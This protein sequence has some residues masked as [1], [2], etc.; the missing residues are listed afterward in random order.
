MSKG[1][2]ISWSLLFG[3]KGS[4]LGLLLHMCLIRKGLG[5]RKITWFSGSVKMR[6][7]F[8]Y[9]K[10]KR[11]PTIVHGLH[12]LSQVKQRGARTALRWLTPPTAALQVSQQT[13]GKDTE[14]DTRV[15]ICSNTSM[16]HLSQ[17]P[18][19]DLG[20][21]YSTW[22]SHLLS[23]ADLWLLHPRCRSREPAAQPA[24]KV[25]EQAGDT[26][27]RMPAVNSLF[28]FSFQ[29]FRN[30]CSAPHWHFWE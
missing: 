7:C 13:Q 12:Q 25:K 14:S 22:L 16:L 6:A 10:R 18:C 23:C 26:P 3:N 28:F 15:V 27:P 1:A 8:P 20:L 9:S 21:Y 19:I 24:Q 5:A 29:E 4:V 2:S 11:A 30:I 17:V